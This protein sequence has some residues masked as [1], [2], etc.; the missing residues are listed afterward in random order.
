MENKVTVGTISR[1]AFLAI[2]LL[3]QF[4]S[5]YGLSPLPVEDADIN[6]LISTGFTAIAA[7]VAWWKN[8]SFTQKAIEADNS[9]K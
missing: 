6:T 9:F 8:N 3:N 4:L 1:T 2:A 5:A 7:L